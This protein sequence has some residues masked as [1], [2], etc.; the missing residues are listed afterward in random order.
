MTESTTS[1]DTA[2]TDTAAAQGGA[3]KRA[4]GLSTMLLA[5]LKQMAGGLGVSGA[6]SMKKADLISAIK[7]AQSQGQAGGQSGG[8][9]GGSAKP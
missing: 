9:S 5:D 7:A 4:G 6:G 3:K 2:A 1:P 8:R